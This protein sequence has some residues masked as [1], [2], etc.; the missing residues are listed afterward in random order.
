MHF[1]LGRRKEGSWKSLSSREVEGT[2]K[3]TR[4][5]K[6]NCS[7]ILLSRSTQSTQSFSQNSVVTVPLSCSKIL[8]GLYHHLQMKTKLLNCTK[9][10]PSFQSHPSPAVSPHLVRYLLWAGHCEDGGGHSSNDQTKAFPSEGS[11]WVEGGQWPSREMKGPHELCELRRKANVMKW[12][13]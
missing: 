5:L 3:V 12:Q 1:P 2:E 8:H 13:K 9:T 10:S 4:T 6:I 7:L 11:H